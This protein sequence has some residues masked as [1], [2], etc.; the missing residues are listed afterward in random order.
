MKN[1]KLIL[2]M[3]VKNE[4]KIIE[5]CFDSVLSIIDGI[6]ISDTGS[7]DNTVELIESYLQKHSMPGKVYHDE[8][9]NFG[10]NRTKSVK[11]GQ[12]WLQTSNF[13]TDFSYFITID[14]D[15]IIKIEPTFVKAQLK[16]KESWLL[17]QKTSNL[18]Y[19]NKR[20]FHSAFPL[21]SIGV[22]HEYWGCDCP[23]SDGKL[24]QIYIDDIGDGGAKA[25]K[26]ERDVRLLTQGLIDEP[27]NERYFFYLA[28]SYSDA[29]NKEEA[30]SWYKKRIAAGGWGEEIYIAHQR[31]G[32]IYISLQESDKALFYWSLGYDYLPTR[33]E[34]LFRIIHMYRI[35]GKNKLAMLY[36]EKALKIEYPK[37][38]VLFIEYPVYQYQ[39]LE[40]L[41]INGYYTDRKVEG[42]IACEY[43][44]HSNENIP[45]NIIQGCLANL[46]F[47]I[48]KLESVFS[49]KL[50]I[51]TVY[52]YCSSSA[53]FMLSEDKNSYIGNVRSVNY[54]ISKK[55]EYS[56]RDENNHVK[57]QNIWVEI[58]SSGKLVKDYQIECNIN[59]LRETHIKGLEDMRLCMVE[60][61]L[62]GLGVT[63]E[64]GNHNHPCVVLCK[65]SKNKESSNYYIESI[66]PTNYKST[67]VQKNWVPFVD[68]KHPTKL[69]A[70]YSYQPL[71]IVEINKKNGD[72]TVFLEKINPN[73]N[74]SRIRGSTSP[75]IQKI[76]SDSYW[77]ILVH[78]VLCRDTRKY[79]HRFLQYTHDWKFVKMSI[80]FYFNELFVEFSLSILFEK[81]NNLTIFYSKEDNSTEMLKINSNDI[82]WMPSDIH[83]WLKDTF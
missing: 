25:D 46:F 10:Y 1:I 70:I 20:I 68:P 82:Q 60:N 71:K 16:E 31:I 36:L 57:T 73:F 37:D 79:Y 30:I 58:D 61:K 15:M 59:P 64:Y 54:S 43:L 63:F 72:T 34:T 18:K 17:L 14:A 67:E 52:P 44:I 76:G 9:K 47:Y 55:F 28:Q 4:S 69:L 29:G 38:Q 40:E 2:I 41:S 42:L 50:S 33:A 3:I 12:E 24:D 77:L 81:N 75:I 78:E 53:S 13:E 19:Y 66:F 6:V 8:W 45:E 62:Y 65:F 49:K 83:L 80:P 74:L 48:P 5:R 21:K 26:F 39:L 27:N 23:I 32:D 51:P 22:T 11:N 7:T 35:M 56:I